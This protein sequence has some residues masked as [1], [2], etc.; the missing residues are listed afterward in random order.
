MI[1]VVPSSDCMQSPLRA[2]KEI[3]C[4]VIVIKITLLDSKNS[5]LI[6]FSHSTSREL[7]L[8]HVGLFVQVSPSPAHYHPKGIKKNNQIALDKDQGSG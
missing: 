7:R 2:Q 8:N 6:F 1:C 4:L 5:D 3:D